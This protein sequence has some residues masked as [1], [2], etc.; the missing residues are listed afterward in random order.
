MVSTGLEWSFKTR[1]IF[2]KST[3]LAQEHRFSAWGKRYIRPPARWPGTSRVEALGKGRHRLGGAGRSVTSR[4]LEGIQRIGVAQEHV[5]VCRGSPEGAT[6]KELKIISMNLDAPPRSPPL[7]WRR[8][9]PPASPRAES[10]SGCT[11]SCGPWAPR[12][13]R[14]CLSADYSPFGDGWEEEFELR[15]KSSD[16]SV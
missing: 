14:C 7:S 9:S 1:S 2:A 11:Q 16:S 8:E 6:P 13:H 5:A 12:N 3:I 4:S 15:S 10:C